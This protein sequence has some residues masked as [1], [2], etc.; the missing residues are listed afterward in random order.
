MVIPVSCDVPANSFC[1]QNEF[2]SYTGQHVPCDPVSI[3]L[4]ATPGELS[5]AFTSMGWCP[6]DRTNFFSAV[7]MVACVAMDLPYHR[8]PV[9][10][11]Y[12]NERP[13]D[14]C[15]EQVLGSPRRRHHIRLWRSG[16]LAPDGRPIWLGAATYD[17]GLKPCL[18]HG[19]VM[20]RIDPNLVAERDYVLARLKDTGWL[21]ASTTL[22]FSSTIFGRN[23]TG[24]R[25][26]TDGRILLGF[27][28][29]APQAERSLNKNAQRHPSS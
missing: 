17:C 27:L 21:Q 1:E 28:T 26:F 5:Q 20:H 10:K 4:V 14:L 2:V 9:S 13:Q 3:V 15:F 12:L 6:S 23:A 24:D 11:L 29:Q 19:L 7:T 25:Y 16:Q 18:T 22:G 8:A